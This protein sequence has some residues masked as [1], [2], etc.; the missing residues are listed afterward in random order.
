MHSREKTVDGVCLC[1]ARRK[2]LELCP[3]TA[4][5]GSCGNG[6]EHREG[7]DTGRNEQAQ[8][9]GVV[10]LLEPG[11]SPHTTGRNR[12]PGRQYGQGVLA[13]HST[14]LSPRCRRARWNTRA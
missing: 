4:L 2:N 7:K 10:Q 13:V 3:V 12:S 8:S 5:S 6:E 11:A 1:S 14:R 9:G